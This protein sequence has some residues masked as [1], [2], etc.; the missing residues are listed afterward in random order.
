MPV[1]LTEEQASNM[2]YS[3]VEVARDIF[4]RAGYPSDFCL[5]SSSRDVYVFGKRNRLQWSAADGWTVL[6][7]SERFR[8][9][10]TEYR[11]L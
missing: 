9:A 6:D 10:A 5:T 2:G 8:D 11:S 3:V 7:G 4:D 1:I